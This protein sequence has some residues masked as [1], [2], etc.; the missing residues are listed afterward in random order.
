MHY[1]VQ[2][3]VKSGSGQWLN[4]GKDKGPWSFDATSEEGRRRKKRKE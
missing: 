3:H 1:T 2:A 4:L